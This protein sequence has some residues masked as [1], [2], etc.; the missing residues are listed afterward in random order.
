MRSILISPFLF[1]MIGIYKIT[2]PSG[3]I[4]IGQSSKIEGRKKKY[5][6][7]A[8]KGQTKLYNSLVKYSFSEHIF[9]IIEECEVGELN[10][11]ER[12]WQD[13]YNVLGENGL[14]LR[15]TQT[16]DKPGKHSKETI[17]KIGNANRGKKR[18]A[19]TK[20][21]RDNIGESLRNSEIFQ[22]A[23]RAPERLLKI[24]NALVGR[25][26]TQEHK[27]SI[28]LAQNL[29]FETCTSWM[30]GKKHTQD[31]IEKMKGPKTKEHIEKN[32]EAHVKYRD[33]ECWT[34]EGVYVKTYRVIT[35]AVKDG[36]IHGSIIKCL[37]GKSATHKKFIWKYKEKE[38]EN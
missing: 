30:K 12:H 18:P 26:L 5:G 15:L 36:F 7:L 9:E 20:T 19:L 4:Y 29:R 38:L 17:E 16:D 33:I 21:H 24:Q 28:R 25:T 10:I 31:A 6:K 3:R 37:L 22:T 11:R 35:E 27:D 14:N 32:K 23:V 1:N 2:S 8:C 13:F 34:S